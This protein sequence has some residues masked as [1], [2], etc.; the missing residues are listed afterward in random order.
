[1][2]RPSFGLC[3]PVASSLTSGPCSRISADSKPTVVPRGQCVYRGSPACHSR[4]GTLGT[5]A[6][7]IAP[8]RLLML[9]IGSSRLEATLYQVDR[10]EPSDRLARAAAG[11]GATDPAGDDADQG[12]PRRGHVDGAALRERKPGRPARQTGG[13]AVARHAPGRG[14]TGPF[15]PSVHH[16]LERSRCSAAP[17]GWRT[18]AWRHL[19]SHGGEVGREP[20][21]CRSGWA[22]CSPTTSCSRSPR[23]SSRAPCRGA[24][25]TPSTTGAPWS[26]TTRGFRESRSHERSRQSREEPDWPPVARPVR[27]VRAVAPRGVDR[28]VERVTVVASV[29][30]GPLL[31][32]ILHIYDRSERLQL[33]L[34]SARVLLNSWQKLGKRPAYRRLGRGIEQ[35]PTSR[36]QRGLPQHPERRRQATGR[37]PLPQAGR[38][39][40]GRVGIQAGGFSRRPPRKL[41][42]QGGPERLRAVY[43]PQPPRQPRRRMLVSGWAAPRVPVAT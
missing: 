25:A 10:P 18:S 43:G 21:D 13:E 12:H 27:P 38:A 39:D 42:S 5:A 22:S 6:A 1:L 3:P 33:G 26:D 31:S 15:S 4:W 8:V 17:R 28:R 19:G 40:S 36:G 9:I 41:L 29:P 20:E 37:F 16:R 23:S 34:Q 35:A 30:H 24:L 14:F 2:P 11:Q 32:L 7:E